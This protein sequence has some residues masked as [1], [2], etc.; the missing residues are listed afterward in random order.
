MLETSRYFLVGF[1]WCAIFVSVLVIIL[2][3]IAWLVRHAAFQVVRIR[4]SPAQGMLT[5]SYLIG[6][7]WDTVEMRV[8]GVAAR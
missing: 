2:A 5:L 7:S 6:L 4:A 8:L 3:A 1:G